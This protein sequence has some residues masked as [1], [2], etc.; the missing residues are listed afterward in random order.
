MR[1]G[2]FAAASLASLA[3]MRP[4]TKRLAARA[5]RL[6]SVPPAPED[7][8][9]IEPG[10]E[11]PRYVI[12]RAEVTGEEARRWLDRFPGLDLAGKSVLDVGCGHGD[13]CLEAARRGAARAVG[14]DIAEQDIKLAASKLAKEGP[15]L[16]VEF[17]TYRGSLT[18]LGDERF[19]IV[20]SKDSFEHYGAYPGSPGP[21]EMVRDMAERLVDG[22]LLAIGFGP[23]WKA[24]YGG[25][26]DVRVPWAHLVFPE[27]VIFDEFRR[28][29]PPGHTARTFEEGTGV[30]RMTLA[31]FRA[32][33]DA[34]G[35]EQ[36]RLD[37]NVGTSRAFKGM[38]VIQRVPGLREYG[39]QNAYGIWRRPAGW[40]PAA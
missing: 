29:R 30:N 4:L 20:M 21:A 1:S 16:P 8:V 12:E 17:R 2:A 7:L 36:I 33:M 26:I 18:E 22:G 10:V 39:T 32:V 37:T 19:D 27:E 9:E 5:Y 11:V 28:T 3:A 35:L 40:A 14:V 15:E 24:P 34:S 25:H 23:L 6:A 38:R 31:R 13:L